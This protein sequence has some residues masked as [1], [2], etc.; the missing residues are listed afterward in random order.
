MSISRV[1]FHYLATE[2]CK[3]VESL[4]NA[5]RAAIKSVTRASTKLFLNNDFPKGIIIQYD[6]L[7]SAFPYVPDFGTSEYLCWLTFNTK[8]N[9]Y[10]QILGSI[11]VLE[12]TSDTVSYEIEFW[13]GGTKLCELCLDKDNPPSIDQMVAVGKRLFELVYPSKPFVA[14]PCA[15]CDTGS[16]LQYFEAVLGLPLLN[17]ENMN[18][19][20]TVVGETNFMKIVKPVDRL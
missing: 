12:D 19:K 2:P 11:A 17:N 15:T 1:G 9:S 18:G 8:K 6:H 7:V 10:A 5:E 3:T 20:Y 4:K 16:M 14:P 13:K